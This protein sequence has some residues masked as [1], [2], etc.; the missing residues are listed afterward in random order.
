MSHETIDK[1]V[2]YP[3]IMVEI[4]HV[5]HFQNMTEHD[6]KPLG[7]ISRLIYTYTPYTLDVVSYMSRADYLPKVG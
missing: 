7:L 2:P 6:G 4:I 1:L 3:P 5:S